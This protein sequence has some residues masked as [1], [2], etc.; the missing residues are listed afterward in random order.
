MA[1]II[2]KRTH[3][4][5]PKPPY[6]SK[7]PRFWE[8]VPHIRTHSLFLVKR[9][10]RR[11]MLNEQPEVPHIERMPNLLRIRKDCTV[12]TCCV[13]WNPKYRVRLRYSCPTSRFIHIATIT[14]TSLENNRI[15]WQQRSR[16]RDQRITRS[17][18]PLM[19]L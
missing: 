11:A 9:R 8:A 7:K 6:Q 5:T 15:S 4:I 2:C 12:T 17:S 18:C 10:P 16:A 13:R 3:R 19:R 1:L 14:P